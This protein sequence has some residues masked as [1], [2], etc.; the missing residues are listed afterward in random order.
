[1][2]APWIAAFAVLWLTVLLL[3]FTMIGIVRRIGGVLEGIEQRMTASPGE[4]GAAVGSTISPFEVVDADGREVA[5]DQLVAEPTLL[6][7]MSNHCA[8]CTALAE[9]LEGVGGSIGDVPFVL[10]TNAEPEVPYPATLRVLYERDGAA[11]KALDNRATP[12]AYV[13]DPTG[14]VLDRKVPGSLRDLVAMAREQRSRAAN[15][16][17]AA[18]DAQAIA[19]GS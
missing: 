16:S 5:F 12:Q 2:S 1:M 19:R 3:T 7:V 14:L 9:Q 15:G 6:L 13:L 17:G 4:F 11:T 18:A 10:V 8:A